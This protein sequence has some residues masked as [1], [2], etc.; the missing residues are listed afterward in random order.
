MISTV[1][2][3]VRLVSLKKNLMADARAYSQWLDSEWGF[4]YH[5]QPQRPIVIGVEE[6]FEVWCAVA[7]E[8]TL[9]YSPRG[10]LMLFRHELIP[11]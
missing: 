2:Y 9:D 3:A 11:A 6:F 5:T 1:Q 7:F 8:G 10:G 4:L